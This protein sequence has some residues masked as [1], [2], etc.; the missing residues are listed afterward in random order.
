MRLLL[1]AFLMLSFSGYAQVLV[2]NSTTIGGEN[3]IGISKNLD[4]MI[5]KLTYD[6]SGSDTMFTLTAMK[7]KNTFIADYQLLLFIGSKQLNNF[8]NTLQTAFGANNDYKAE[9]DVNGVAVT[10]T[11]S[12]LKGTKYVVIT[13]SEGAGYLTAKHVDQTFGK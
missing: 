4:V 13:T 6:V 11:N 5:S 12:K 7:G 3:V 1:I 9:V 10:I 8:Y 2:K